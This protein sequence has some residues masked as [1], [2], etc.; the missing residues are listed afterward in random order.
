MTDLEKRLADMQALC[1]RAHL[2]LSE[3]WDK[4][5]DDEGCGPATL[6]RQLEKAGEG[7]ELK[8]ISLFNDKLV[9]ICNGQADEIKELNLFIDANT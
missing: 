6:L 3:N 7:K 2:I 5:T 1:K 9:R 8:D 4:H